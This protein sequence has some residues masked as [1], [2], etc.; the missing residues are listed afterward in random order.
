MKTIT[1][2]TGKKAAVLAALYNFSRPQGMGFL[3]Y[4]PVPMTEEGAQ[5]L[6][7]SGVTYFDYLKGRVMKVELGG[8]AF[9]TWLYDRD[10]GQ[11][12]AYEAVK[13]LL[14]EEQKDERS[15]ATEDAQKT[16]A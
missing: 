15:V 9:E 4:E 8:N 14:N 5:N 11:G 13:H 3:Q 6:L 16:N 10:N 12:A 7:D 2:P 1:I